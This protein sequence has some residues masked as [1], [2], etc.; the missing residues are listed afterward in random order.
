[1]RDAVMSGG[2]HADV[3]A[4]AVRRLEAAGFQVDYAVIR[5]SDLGEAD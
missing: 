2:V 3:E 5:L 1:M 4:E